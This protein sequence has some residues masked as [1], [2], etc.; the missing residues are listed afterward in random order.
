MMVVVGISC[1]VVGILIGRSL[2]AGDYMHGHTDGLVGG[3]FEE[4]TRGVHRDASQMDEGA[5]ANH[6]IHLDFLE[7]RVEDIF[8]TAIVPFSPQLKENWEK[9][10]K[11]MRKARPNPASRPIAAKRGSG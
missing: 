10:L 7:N 6:N 4:Y 9:E 1:I 5:L 3:I 8:A 2:R 11:P